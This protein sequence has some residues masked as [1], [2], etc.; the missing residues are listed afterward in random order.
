MAAEVA[1]AGLPARVSGFVTSLPAR[2]RNV[3]AEMKKVTWPDRTQ[4][5]QATIGIIAFVLFIGAVITLMDLV[6][7]SVLVRGIPSLFTGR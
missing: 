3:V 5:R 7:Q 4:V 2:Y 1:P 6:L